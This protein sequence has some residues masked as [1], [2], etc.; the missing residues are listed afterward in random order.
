MQE[1][2]NASGFDV[3][4]AQGSP[5]GGPTA[6]ETA[7]AEA[8]AAAQGADVIVLNLG[9]GNDVEGEGQDRVFLTFPEPQI[10]LLEAL[11]K[12]KG[13]IC[14]LLAR[15]PPLHSLYNTKVLKE[16]VVGQAKLVLAIMSAGGVDLDPTLADAIVQLWYGGQETGHGLTDVLWG[17]LNPSGRMPLT[18]HPTSYLS[19]GVGNV[20]NLNM[21]FPTPDGHIQGRTYRYL[22][23]QGADTIFSF[24]W[25]LSYTQF[26][27]SN[28][29]ANATAV[30]VDVKNVGAVGG[31]EVAELYLGDL[32]APTNALPPVPYALAGFEKVFLLP[33]DSATVTFALVPDQL[34]VVNSAGQR[35][36]A[37]GTVKVYVA[38]HLPSD[39]R[40]SNP[41][42]SK[43]V[44]NVAESS[45]AL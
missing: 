16:H 13:G 44:S 35:V 26:Q 24:G 8:V 29:F 11:A 43:H 36:P 5:F 30:T 14:A 45:F 40:A 23:D 3:I 12:S 38:G 6:N 42:N 4:F 28:I 33:G 31:A 27:Y 10:A 9:L 1:E 18:V 17:R 22:A 15:P 25:G 21:T 39:P 2:G 20:S 34:T 32:N 7:I 37:S 19:S 41:A